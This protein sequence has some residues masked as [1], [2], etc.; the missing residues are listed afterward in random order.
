M[1]KR[2][3]KKAMD[4]ASVDDHAWDVEQ[5]QGSD[6]FDEAEG[7]IEKADE[8]SGGYPNRVREGVVELLVVGLVVGVVV[9]VAAAAAAAARLFACPVSSTACDTLCHLPLA[10]GHRFCTRRLHPQ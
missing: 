1:P 8:E 9:V 3:G 5:Q 4:R 7:V 2:P 10:V 6:T